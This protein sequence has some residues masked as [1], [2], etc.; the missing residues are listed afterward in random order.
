[1][2]E[3]D[4]TKTQARKPTLLSSSVKKLHLKTTAILPQRPEETVQEHRLSKL[5]EKGFGHVEVALTSHVA[6]DIKDKSLQTA[7]DTHQSICEEMEESID[8]EPQLKAKG[9]K[10]YKHVMRCFRDS[11]EDL[12][13]VKQG[14][15]SEMGHAEKLFYESLKRAVVLVRERAED[16][17]TLSTVTPLPS[18]KSQELDKAIASLTRKIS[19]CDEKVESTEDQKRLQLELGQLTVRRNKLYS[20]DREEER[21]IQEVKDRAILS[22][23]PDGFISLF[24]AISD[25]VSPVLAFGF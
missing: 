17:D 6:F 10:S 24:Y 4:D 13:K 16:A 9:K 23:G 20:E 21:D 2:S 3:P 22:K 5:L 18:L 11:P 1:M 14:L 15:D 7:L 8:P 12:A 25:Q 19:S